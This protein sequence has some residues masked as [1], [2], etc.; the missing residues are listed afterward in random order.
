MPN[1]KFI[2]LISFY[3]PIL[4]QILKLFNQDIFT[5]YDALKIVGLWSLVFSSTFD[6]AVGSSAAAIFII[7]QGLISAAATTVHPAAL[8]Q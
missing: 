2:R 8:H 6:P 3:K 7:T 5:G 1:K 4:L